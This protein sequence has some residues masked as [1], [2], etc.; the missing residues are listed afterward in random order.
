MRS[1][2]PATLA[3]VVFA[4]GLCACAS[5]YKQFYVPADGA[6]PEAIS[7]FRAGPA[8]AMPS[9]ERSAPANAEEILAAYAKRGFVMIGHSS[10]NSGQNE[11]E[12]SALQQGKAVGADL[13]LV[14]NPQ[15]T[16]SVTT[17]IPLTTPTTSTAYTSGTA[18]AF[19]PSGTVT[20][21]GN[22]TTTVQ[23]STTTYIPMTVHRSDYTAVYF[24][25][26]RFNLG[27]FVR[28]LEDSERQAF[29][30]NQ[31]VIVL[32]VVD[33]TPAF[34]ADI[35]SGDMI[36][37]I[38]GATVSTQDHFSEIL[39]SRRGSQVAIVLI[40]GGQKIEKLVQLNR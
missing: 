30:T 37:S 40:R 7:S 2:R 5:G 9:I 38:D 24:V 31:G 15:Y 11:P 39:E 28:N 27:T 19:G 16:G 1:I 33:N 32:T 21:Y 25:K 23:G 8:P 6:S 3:V 10:F 35:L 14:M 12:S 26:Q 22:A 13:V 34:Y 4:A 29:Q 36:V 17:S 18:T 20:A